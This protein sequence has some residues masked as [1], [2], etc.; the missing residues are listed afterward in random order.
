M[1]TISILIQ[2]HNEERNIEQCI[3]SAHLLSDTVVVV[4]M[5]STD[6]TEELAVKNGAAV[7]SF[8]FSQYVEPGRAFG[9]QKIQTDWVFILDAD[10]RMTERLAEEIQ[11]AIMNEEFAYYKVPRKNMFGG[12]KWLQHGGWWP[13]EQMRL[14]QVASFES[15][16]TQIHSTPYIRG[17]M[18][19]LKNEFEHHFHGNIEAM[20]QKTLVF[21]N[22]ESDLLL[23]AGKH[24][25]TPTFFRKFLMELWRRLFQK[26]GFLDG[27]VG[28]IESVYQAYSKT[29]T[30]LLLYE[31]K[32]RRPVHPLS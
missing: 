29:I 2:T 13:D 12:K 31:K 21:E 27:T 1:N 25:K 3:A 16:P 20:V 14:M 5:E 15:W 11:T 26:M 8:P 24:V 22:I 17:R 32:N 23:E 10:E 4:D 28:I 9:L 30:Y 6:K 7:T 18:G 19:H